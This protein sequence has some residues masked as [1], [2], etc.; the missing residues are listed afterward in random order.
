MK[1]CG[2]IWKKLRRN[3]NSAS[4]YTQRSP[5]TILYENQIL[6]SL[7]NSTVKD[8]ALKEG[9]GC[10]AVMGVFKRRVNA[11]TD[12]KTIGRIDF[13]GLDEVSLKK[14]HKD[15]VA[16]VS[17]LSGDELTVPAVLE[18]REKKTV[19][20]FLKNVPKKIK[21]KLK[22]V[23][24]DM[25]DGYINA[26]KEA[27]GKNI[28][29]TADRFHAVK[30]YKKKFENL[31]K[32]EMKRLQKELQEEEYKKLK[33]VMRALRKKSGKLND[34]QR[35]TLEILFKHSSVLKQA[36]DLCND[37]SSIYEEKISK[38]EAEIK[39]AGRV[40]QVL[41]S[42]LTCF[43][44]FLKTLNRRMEEITNYFID[45]Q[46]SGFVEGLN[47]KIKALERRCYGIQN[48]GHLFQRITLDMKGYS[49]FA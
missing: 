13:I 19:K 12:W 47:N 40:T 32:K 45:R 30:L 25:Y 49:M 11:E 26:A 23:C 48:I 20:Q 36:Y 8:A 4:W 9:I 43:N 27:L 41:S 44:S 38:T 35:E 6:V 17:A 10:E 24:S 34:E 22:G 29:I 5:L 16:V 2:G 37:L 31:R 7:I 42:G 14:G 33:G 21:K 39:I 18:G 3:R 15:F 46:T 28:K 1:H